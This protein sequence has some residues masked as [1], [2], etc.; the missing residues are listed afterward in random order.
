MEACAADSL[1]KANFFKFRKDM[2]DSDLA[3]ATLPK[4]LLTWINKPE[5]DRLLGQKLLREMANKTKIVGYS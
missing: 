3:P 2:P 4:A 1:S 5:E